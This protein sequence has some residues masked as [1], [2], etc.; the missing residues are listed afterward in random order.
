MGLTVKWK[1]SILLRY[2][3]NTIGLRFSINLQNYLKKTLSSNLFEAT[4]NN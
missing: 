3:Y 2:I 1:Q 4:E